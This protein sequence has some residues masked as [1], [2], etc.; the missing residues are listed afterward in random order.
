[1]SRIR[2]ASA[3]YTLGDDFANIMQAIS[4]I[5]GAVIGAVGAGVAAGAGDNKEQATIGKILATS[6]Q[7]L[8]Q[9]GANIASLQNQA[10]TQMLS[11][12]QPVTPQQ[13]LRQVTQQV[14]QRIAWLPYAVVGGTIVVGGIVL[15][16]ALGR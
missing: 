4:G 16:L 7:G 5:G 8:T 15:W 12:L 11:V 3:L 6:G 13:D 2:T 9:V 1:M 14:Q 10:R